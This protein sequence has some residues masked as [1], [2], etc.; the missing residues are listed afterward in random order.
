M[1]R[2]S[3]INMGISM[4]A[5]ATCLYLAFGQEEDKTY[6]F[7]FVQNT[8]I[9]TD[10]MGIR[11]GRAIYEQEVA[12]YQ[13]NLDTLQAELRQRIDGFKAEYELMSTDE[14]QMA[15]EL[16]TKYQQEIGNYQSAMQQTLQ[17]KDE[18]LTE[19]VLSQIDNYIVEYGESNG[20]DYIFGATSEGS[21]FY[22]AEAQDLTAQVIE[23]LNNTYNGE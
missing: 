16:I 1:K 17:A 4:L 5:L 19:A 12:V 21:L 8:Q 3:I 22:A 2:L 15:T 13:S 7:G 6:K 14:Q 9:L 18:Q 11:E 20:Y 23:G 10:Y